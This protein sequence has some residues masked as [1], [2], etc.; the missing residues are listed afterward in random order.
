MAN[1]GGVLVARGTAHSGE[2]PNGMSKQYQK[3][4][5]SDTGPTN[6]IGPYD[7]GTILGT[8]PP[9]KAGLKLVDGTVQNATDLICNTSPLGNTLPSTASK[10]VVGTVQTGVPEVNAAQVES[11]GLSLAP[12]TE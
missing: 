4:G 2:Q 10:V 1:D 8:V 3:A 9:G 6:T 12:Q 11:A 7:S 5:T